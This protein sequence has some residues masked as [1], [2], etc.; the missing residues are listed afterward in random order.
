MVF[1]NEVAVGDFHKS[2]VEPKHNGSALSKSNIP[3]KDTTM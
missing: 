1:A 3:L 2:P